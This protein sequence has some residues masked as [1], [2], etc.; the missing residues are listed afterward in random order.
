MGVSVDAE[1]FGGAIVD[2]NGRGAGL[3][4]N[5]E[6]HPTLIGEIEHP[7]LRAAQVLPAPALAGDRRIAVD[8]DEHRARAAPDEEEDADLTRVGSPGQDALECDCLARRDRD[9]LRINRRG[10]V[11]G[12]GWG[13]RQG[14]CRN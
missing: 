2:A 12:Q 8:L 9:R 13:G 11:V 10:C 3:P 14:Q 6:D 1:P 7:L 5:Q 4:G